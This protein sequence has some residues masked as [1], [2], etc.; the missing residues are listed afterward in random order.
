MFKEFWCAGAT[1]RYWWLSAALMAAY[2]ASIQVA[3]K[4]APDFSS[5]LLR[6]IAVLT[7]VVPVAGF[8][9]LEFRRIRATDELRQRM[10][11]EAGML[12]LATGM[13]LL[14][15][16]GLLDNAELLDI[17]MLLQTGPSPAPGHGRERRR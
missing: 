2:M 9:W 10:E 5:P 14:L 4:W 11:L 3:V 7:P 16:L 13:L 15:A 6:V 1:R 8:V 12:T 17:Q